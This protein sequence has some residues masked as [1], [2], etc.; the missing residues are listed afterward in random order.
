MSGCGWS[1]MYRFAAS[2]AICFASDVLSVHHRL[3]ARP[4]QHITRSAHYTLQHLVNFSVGF[5][6]IAP[7]PPCPPPSDSPVAATRSGRAAAAARLRGHWRRRRRRSSAH[8]AAAAAAVASASG[9]CCCC[10]CCSCCCCCRLV[11]G[12]VTVLATVEHRVPDE[13]GDLRLRAWE[14]IAAYL[15]RPRA[16]RHAL[17]R[18]HEREGAQPISVTRE[19]GRAESG[20]KASR[21]ARENLGSSRQ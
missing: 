15:R 20:F 8:A 2:R 17:Q 10:C 4:K 1:G 19:H 21:G 12:H 18:R 16:A 14:E 9:C 13:R 3:T 5:H 11:D 6:P 7:V